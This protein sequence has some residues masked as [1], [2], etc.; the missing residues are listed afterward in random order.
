MLWDKVASPCFSWMI[1]LIHVLFSEWSMICLIL[2][3]GSLWVGFL[4]LTSQSE[5]G[6]GKTTKWGTTS[7]QTRITWSK[8]RMRY[9]L[10]VPLHSIRHPIDLGPDALDR[11]R[12]DVKRPIDL[13]RPSVC[14]TKTKWVWS[15]SDVRVWLI[16]QSKIVFHGFPS[17]VHSFPVSY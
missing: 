17:N 15:T 5:P 4:Y 16:N 8:N 3:P 2:L 6:K 12:N 14:L 13:G 9:P 10:K 1:S 7:N 11:H